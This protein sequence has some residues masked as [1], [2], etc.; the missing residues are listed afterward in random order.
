MSTASRTWKKAEQTWAE[1]H[2][3][4]RSGPTG[5]DS[6]DVTTVN[7]PI[8]IEHKLQ[9]KRTLRRVFVEQARENAAAIGLPWV[10]ILHEKGTNA[11]KED[12]IVMDPTTYLGLISG[13][14]RFEVPE[15]T[16]TLAK[17]LLKE[18]PHAR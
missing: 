14:L 1:L 3:E 4:S 2:G 5:R 9:T 8:G 13:E 17:R 15:S 18:V 10:L 11:V 7:C 16:R 12:Y 6:C